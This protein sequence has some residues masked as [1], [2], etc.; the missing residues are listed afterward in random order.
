MRTSIPVLVIAGFLGSGKTTL[1]NHLLRNNC[2][3]RIG[4]MVNDFGAINVDAML[5]AGQVDAMVSLSNGCICCEVDSED[6]SGMLSKLASAQPRVDVIALEA[7]GVADPGALARLVMAAD[8]P[9]F[10]FAGV[11]LVVDSDAVQGALTGNSDAGLRGMDVMQQVRVAD[12]VLLNKF[13]RVAPS[14]LDHIRALISE[15]HPSVP[16]VPTTYCR[17]D[18]GLLFDPISRPGRTTQAEQLSFDQLVLEDAQREDAEDHGHHHPAFQ[19]VAWSST[20]PLHP[21]RFMTFLE[22]RPRGVYRAKGV[23]DFGTFG[24][25]SRFIL[26][27]VGRSLRI[28][29]SQWG[30]A[31]RPAT[32]LVFIGV[33]VEEDSVQSRLEAC[34][35]GPEDGPDQ[36]AI[37]S[38]LKYAEH[39]DELATS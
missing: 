22:N 9:G 15:Q 19:S 34:V 28:E 24:D 32:Q 18:S 29:Q 26:Q 37:L 7:S 20:E 11:I 3:V 12:L 14:Q 35:V 33:D 21:R 27:M 4:V 31:E 38:V 25:G 17:V 30:K 10:H 8:D 5:V 36:Y 1:L 23:I 6:I 16:V 2:G 13:D 39:E